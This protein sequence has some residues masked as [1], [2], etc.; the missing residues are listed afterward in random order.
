MH[1]FPKL[2]ENQYPCFESSVRTAKTSS[3]HFVHFSPALKPSSLKLGPA[4]NV[5]FVQH[6]QILFKQLN[7]NQFNLGIDEH[8]DGIAI[9]ET[10]WYLIGFVAKKCQEK[11]IDAH[12]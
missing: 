6:C 9:S 1:V 11:K 3:I 2:Y 4:P 10:Q 12:V 5:C 7:S 8:N